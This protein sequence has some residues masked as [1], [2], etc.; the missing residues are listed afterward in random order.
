MNRLLKKSIR[1]NH[2]IGRYPWLTRNGEWKFFARQHE[3]N[4]GLK[5]ELIC[6]VRA[7]PCRS[8][9]LE[10]AERTVT[11]IPC[12]AWNTTTPHK[13]LILPPFPNQAGA[14][15]HVLGE[16]EQ[17]PW[18]YTTDPERKWEYCALPRCAE[19][20]I[21]IP[22]DEIESDLN[23]LLDAERY[24]GR[25]NCQSR[26]I[27]ATTSKPCNHP[28]MAQIAYSKPQTF[29]DHTRGQHACGASIIGSCWVIT[30]AHCLMVSD[31]SS[32]ARTIQAAVERGTFQA[33]DVKDIFVHE[34]FQVISETGAANNDI[35]LIQLKPDHTGKCFKFDMETGPICM[36]R[37]V[38]SLK[39]RD[40]CYITGWGRTSSEPGARFSETIQRAQVPLTKFS[41][42][43]AAYANSS[44]RE[45]SHTRP[46]TLTRKQHLCAAELGAIDACI[47][48]SG[49]PLD[50][51]DRRTQR[52]SLAGLVSFGKQ[53]A[54]KV[55][56]GVYTNVAYYREWI[57]KIIKNPS[58]HSVVPRNQNLHQ[59]MNIDHNVLRH[60]K[61]SN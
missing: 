28:W 57:H 36:P 20:G 54:D 19:D 34:N 56:P 1:E 10:H 32:N 7:R 58:A 16:N 23:E 42:C 45:I 25:S 22:E 41:D 60:M 9:S 29:A 6:E 21:N 30:A 33:I 11:G 61:P 40:S 44:V 12:Q 4:K 49:G 35:A 53:C 59:N 39:V 55:Y 27:G 24:C 13:P 50:C 3:I 15:C 47:G 52:Q 37:A 8:G 38:D 46:V 31:R 43:R 14:R 48:D 51:F 18:C 17:L 26:I 5:R 2:N